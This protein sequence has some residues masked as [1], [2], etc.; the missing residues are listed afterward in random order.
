V[1]LSKLLV[2]FDKKEGKKAFFLI[3]L[4][5]FTALVDAGG[6]ASILP[7]MAVLSNPS[8][9]ETNFYLS[10]LFLFSGLSS[11]KSFLLLLGLAVFILMVL[12]LTLKAV[13]LYSTLRY[14]RLLEHSLSSK[15]IDQYL[16]QPYC[17]FFTRNSSDLSKSIVSEASQVVGNAVMP[18]MQMFSH[19]SV[20]IAM[21]VL[22]MIVNFQLALQVGGALIAVYLVLYFSVNRKLTTIGQS[23]LKF[24]ESRFKTLTEAFGGIKEIKVVGFEEIY[25]QGFRAVSKSFA[26]IEALAP[27]IAQLPRYLLEIVAFGSLLLVTLFFLSETNDIQDMIPVLSLFAFAGYRLMPA[28]QQFYSYSTMLRYARPAV[29][30]M[31]DELLVH[32]KTDSSDST[33]PAVSFNKSIELTNISYSYDDSKKTIEDVNLSIGKNS[34][35][36]FVGSTG[37][38]KTTLVDIILRLIDADSG[39]F[40]I[41]GIPVS[42]T[43]K[44]SLQKM[45]GYVPQSIFLSDNTIAKNIAFGCA[46]EEIHYEQLKKASSVANIHDFIESELPLGYDTIIGERGIRLSGGQRQRLGIARALYRNPEL[47]VFDEATSALDNLTEKKVINSLQDIGNKMTIIMIAHRLSTVKLCDQIHVFKNGKIVSSGN[48]NYLI[49]NCPYFQAISLGSN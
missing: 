15:L 36:G 13:T 9:I 47:L 45:I 42:D 18:V 29:D 16:R 8:I 10:E 4:M 11:E 23:R 24:N 35:V 14:V 27:V 5:V 6:V 25:I 17:W 43:N 46:E 34:L 1:Y 21:T 48:Y 49:E 41:D 39:S 32:C 3:M 22:I 44:K 40:L 19:G 28:M 7:F 26:K 38:G 2:I 37:S 20:V 31:F 33:K 30:A 12:A